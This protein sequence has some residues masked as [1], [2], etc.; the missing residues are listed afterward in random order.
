MIPAGFRNDTRGAGLGA[1]RTLTM[2]ADATG[3]PFNLK[4]P[5][6]SGLSG[7]GAAQ[8]ADSPLYALV[9][10]AGAGAGGAL[11]G[12]VAAGDQR[13]M[14]KGASFAAGM[15]GVSGGL[16]TWPSQR[17]LGAA[18]VTLGLGGMLYALRDR[19]SGKKRLWKR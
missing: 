16:S 3:V 11:I 7:L 8:S 13:G 10:L 5:Q 17:M 18:M 14:I 2:P 6:I 4:P 15:T 9:M 12:W 19:F 1:V